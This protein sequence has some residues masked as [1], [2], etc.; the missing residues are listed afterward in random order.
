MTSTQLEEGIQI[1]ND[2]VLFMHNVVS[3]FG[4]GKEESKPISLGAN[5]KGGMDNNEFAL[6]LRTAIMP[7]YPNAAPEKGKG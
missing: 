7:L 1:W 5:E 6:Y 3:E 4:L 2:C